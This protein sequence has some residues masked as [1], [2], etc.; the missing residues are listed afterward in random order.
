MDETRGETN[1]DG[2]ERTLVLTGFIGNVLVW[3]RTDSET[4]Q[5]TKRHDAN[6]N[7]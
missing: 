1:Q 5:G 3:R 2:S 7:N 4:K 6:K